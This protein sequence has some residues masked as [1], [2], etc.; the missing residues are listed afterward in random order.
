[1]NFEQWW[2]T[3]GV[4]HPTQYE[5]SAARKAFDAATLIEREACAKL[6]ES[7]AEQRVEFGA[8]HRAANAIRARSNAVGKPTP[9]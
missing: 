1:M 6:V 5:T 4:E 9:D 3:Q 8:L 7:R 2:K